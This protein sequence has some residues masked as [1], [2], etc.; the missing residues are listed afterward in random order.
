[1]VAQNSLFDL[2]L[3]GQAIQVSQHDLPGL[4]RAADSWLTLR[5]TAGKCSLS[6]QL[7]GK[8]GIRKTL[9]GD[10]MH[11][12]AGDQAFSRHLLDGDG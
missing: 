3:N 4:S 11:H 8:R 6:E 5:G 12:L 1:M 7:D 9:T 2:L 10:R